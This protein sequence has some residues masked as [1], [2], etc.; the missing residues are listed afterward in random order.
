MNRL[1]LR[2]ALKENKLFLF[3]ILEGTRLKR[4][5]G[6]A[7]EEQLALLCRIIH[8]TF[9]GVWPITAKNLQTI[10]KKRKFQELETNFASADSCNKL[11]TNSSQAKSALLTVSTVLPLILEPIK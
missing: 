5:I 8:E 6:K 10:K 2:R 4:K 11:I 7:T 1:A 3:N 9:A